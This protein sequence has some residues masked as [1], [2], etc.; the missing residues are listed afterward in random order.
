MEI[1]FTDL[2]DKES[3]NKF[4]VSRELAREAILTP[5]S[6]EEIAYKGLQLQF[7]TK[8]TDANRFLLVLARKVDNK[9]TVDL[10]FEV[11][12]NLAE[13]LQIQQPTSVLQKLVEKYG[14]IVTIGN[15][16]K[17]IIIAQEIDL[18]PEQITSLVAIKN[19]DNHS[20]VTSM[21]IK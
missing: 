20:F 19:P 9:I 16:S 10:A 6:S 15:I 7:F 18:K 3:R 1:N 8:K 11:K 13:T 2:F 5:L 14:L 17:K 21:F 4:G 12:A